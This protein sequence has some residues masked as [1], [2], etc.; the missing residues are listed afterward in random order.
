VIQLNPLTFD[1]GTSLDLDAVLNAG[2]AKVVKILRVD[3]GW[4]GLD[5]GHLGPR[6]AGA[7]GLNYE[8]SLRALP[9][10]GRTLELVCHSGI[11]A[12]RL[13]ATASSVRDAGMLDRV[14][15]H[16]ETVVVDDTRPA[17]SLAMS[18][19]LPEGIRTILA[20][21][22]ESQGRML[23]V[24]A[25]VT[26]G[27]HAY[28]ADDIDLA[29]TAAGE[30]ASAIDHALLFRE[31]QRRIDRQSLLI[32]AAEM[33]NRSLDSFSLET[34]VLAEATR[35]V[36]AQKSALLVV[37][38]DVLVAN[39]V[40][41][42]SERYKRVLVVPLEDSLI[43]RAVLNG[44][45]VAVDDAEREGSSAALLAGEG[46]YRALIA[47]P[48]QS[49]RGTYGALA[50]FYAQPQRLGETDK[51]LLR[52]F[53]IHAAI[54]LDNRRLIQEKDQM[55]VHDGLTGVY[56]RSY[57]E[58]TLERTNKELR[59]N[60]GVVSILFLDVDGMKRVNDSHGHQ[61]GDRLL[62]ELATLL[63]ESCRETDIVARYGGDEFV[64]L[65]PGTDSEGARRVARKV[66]EAI[67]QHNAA[68]PGPVRLSASV[69]M[70]TAGGV[71]IDDLLREA[72]RRMYAMKRSRSPRDGET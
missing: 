21:P 35:L 12:D 54:A 47:A 39:E 28:L 32:E 61:A 10:N 37:R 46:Q 18:L 8:P 66:D 5:E 40:F 26:R 27:V 58:L 30:L 68:D 63:G 15:E 72:D 45:T 59:R 70:H 67:A 9:T 4:I 23:G 25:L 31:Q 6:W 33:V 53:S 2:L 64:V 38:G 42:F 34:T 41:G 22:L 13:S 17:S 20:L 56:N 60:G 7:S 24:L 14:T 49:Y 55:A 1:A 48:L 11:T 62:C 3:G 65:M 69:G 71:G 36:G 51:T 29:T 52:T 16:R 19:T 43:G 50:V 57:L 44:E